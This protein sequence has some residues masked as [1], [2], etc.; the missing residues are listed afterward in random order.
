MM[1]L[2]LIYNRRFLYKLYVYDYIRPFTTSQA[3]ITS[4]LTATPAVLHLVRDKKEN[5]YFNHLQVRNHNL[6]IV[7]LLTAG[8]CTWFKRVSI[9]CFKKGQQRRPDVEFAKCLT[10]ARFP[11]FSIPEETRKSWHFWQKIEKGGCF[12]HLCLTYCQLLWNYLL[13]YSCS[14]CFSRLISANF[15]DFAIFRVNSWKFYLSQKISYMSAIPDI[16]DKW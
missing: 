11:K 4:L 2:H 6:Y 15:T 14:S 8:A 5:Y 3:M 7:H 10:S 1:L 13:K 9:H 12:T 16:R